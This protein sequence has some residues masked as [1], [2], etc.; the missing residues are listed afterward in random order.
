VLNARGGNKDDRES[1]SPEKECKRVEDNNFH[2]K[3]CKG[4]TMIT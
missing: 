3:R 1:W 4:R 2:G